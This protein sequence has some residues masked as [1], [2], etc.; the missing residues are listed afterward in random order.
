[1]NKPL[2]VVLLLI[3]CVAI[4]A[5]LATR[6]KPLSP[7]LVEAPPGPAD[8]G[9][10]TGLSTPMADAIVFDLRYIPQ[11]G[12]ADDIEYHG[13]WGYGRS[14]REPQ[15]KSFLQD[16]RKKATRLYLVENP[17]FKGREWAAV[18]YKNRRALAFYFDLNAD[19]KLQ[20]IERIPPTRKTDQGL[21]FIT[22]DFVQ[23]LEAGGETLTRALLRVDFYQGS[24][25]PNCMWSPAA[26]MEGT[27]TFNGQPAR[28]LLF[29]RGPGGQF[30]D[31]GSSSYSFL[32][33]DRVRTSPGQY[34]G[35]GPL[36]T[37]ILSDGRFYHLTIEGKRSNG[38]PAR[39]LLAKDT[40]PTGTL[41]VRLIGANSLPATLTSAF[42][43]GLDDKT[44]FLSVS[45]RM[46]NLSL[47]VG[48]YAV[49]TGT[50]SYAASNSPEWEV[51]FSR[52]PHAKVAARE[53]VEVALGLPTIEV[54]AVEERQ[55]YDPQASG[56]ATFKKGARIY[57]EPTIAGRNREVF[58]RFRQPKELRAGKA[59]RPPSITITN[60]DGKQMLSTTMEYG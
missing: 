4:A 32:V 39:A 26:V 3:V 6:L 2:R 52:G 17:S 59:E 58:S 33:G 35:R 15:N 27:A 38:L 41:A 51:S 49:E 22:P 10:A 8:L 47:P 7:T 43:R 45:S 36:S 30:D 50:A 44:V 23:A 25:E 19:G 29:A 55:R 48:T 31:Y 56:K 12:A 5:I 40:S 11:T 16:V 1:M 46:T 53:K 24:S 60:Q 21:D 9:P 34:I 20:E 14:T 37:L 57:L 13:Y 42:L 18:E 54:R 28:L